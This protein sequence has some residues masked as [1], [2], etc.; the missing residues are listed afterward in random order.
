[1]GKHE[2]KKKQSATRSA[3]PWARSSRKRNG[4]LIGQSNSNSQEAK[5]FKAA[6]M[7]S[8]WKWQTYN[9]GNS[10][11]KRR[12]SRCNKAAKTAEEALAAEARHEVS[13]QEQADKIAEKQEACKA[14]KATLKQARDQAQVVAQAASERHT[15]SRT[16]LVPKEK[17]SI[18]DAALSGEEAKPTHDPEILAK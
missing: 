3:C 7:P 14:K 10:V 1:M 11:L 5:P 17:D 4:S 6:S 9:K 12:G 2:N 18:G 16:A 13:L 15:A 8:N